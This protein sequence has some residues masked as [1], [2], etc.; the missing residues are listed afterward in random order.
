MIS[1]RSLLASGTAGMAVVTWGGLSASSSSASSAGFPFTL[2]DA[3]WR[4]RLTA[5]QYTVLRREGTERPFTSSLLNEKRRGTFACAGCDRDAFSSTTKYDSHTG[6]PSF[7][8]ALPDGVGTTRDQ[9]LG[10]ARTAVHCASCGG[11]LGHVFEDGP[12]PTGLR[13]CMNGVAMMFRPASA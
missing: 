8:S 1:R 6:W 10:M 2:T 5:A 9:T 13:Y 11:H 3:E 12:Q 7:W 4:K